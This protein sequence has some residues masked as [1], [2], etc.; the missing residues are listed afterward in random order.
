[1]LCYIFLQCCNI[2]MYVSVI[3]LKFSVKFC[4][5]FWEQVNS[6]SVNVGVIVGQG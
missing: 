4:K 6:E 5:A 2:D 3:L 1:M